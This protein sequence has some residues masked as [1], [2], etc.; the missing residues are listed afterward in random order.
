MPAKPKSRPSRSRSV[1][2][3]TIAVVIGF[4]LIGLAAMAVAFFQ[5]RPAKITTGVG[6]VELGAPSTAPQVVSPPQAGTSVHV[7][8]TGTNSPVVVGSGSISIG[9]GLAASAA[10]RP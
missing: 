7:V 4:S 6:S 9:S 3:L 5:Y 10:A 8:S 2:R 1:P